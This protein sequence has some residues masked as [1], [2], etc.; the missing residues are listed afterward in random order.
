MRKINKLWTHKLF[1]PDLL[2]H[3]G[4]KSKDFDQ[5]EFGDPAT[6]NVHRSLI[7]AD[8]SRQ[9]LSFLI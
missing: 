6:G 4:N 2:F 8:I 7:F 9:K 1:P 3:D 5:I